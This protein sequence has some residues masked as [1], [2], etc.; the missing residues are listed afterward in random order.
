MMYDL[1]ETAKLLER[2]ASMGGPLS[3]NAMEHARRVYACVRAESD[4]RTWLAEWDSREHKKPYSE[5]DV[6]RH[7]RAALGNVRVD[8][9]DDRNG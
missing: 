8:R 7:L 3:G 2:I 6:V 9:K 1:T 5:P 4:A